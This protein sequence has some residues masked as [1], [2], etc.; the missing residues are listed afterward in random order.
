MS[1]LIAFVG[2][3]SIVF[4]NL[5]QSMVSANS[6]KSGTKITF[7]TQEPL[8]MDG[9]KRLGLVLWFDRDTIKA[10]LKQAKGGAE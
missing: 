3:D 2:D 4:Q 9:T 6:G 5:D 7:G 1:E 8:V 10:A